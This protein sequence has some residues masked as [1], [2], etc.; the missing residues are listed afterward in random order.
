MH[1]ELK[2]LIVGLI[3]VTFSILLAGSMRDCVDSFIQLTVPVT[4]K[5]LSGAYLF[6]WRLFYFI[7][8]LSLLTIA[9]IC[10][11]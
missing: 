2:L 11:V 1:Q 3:L 6:L 4:E 8:I 7:L 10:L 5:S 9:S